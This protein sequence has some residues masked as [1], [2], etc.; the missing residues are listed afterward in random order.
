M[1][2]TEDKL[3]GKSF[4]FTGTLEH[5]KPRRKA[6]ESVIENGGAIENSVVGSLDFLV[7]NSNN[8][9][10]K[11]KKAQSQENTKIISEEEY[12]KMIE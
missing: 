2:K 9:T 1:I 12:L 6:E 5:F 7:T 4:C 3:D 8:P 11:Y 10:N